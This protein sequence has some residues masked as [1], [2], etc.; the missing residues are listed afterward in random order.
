MAPLYSTLVA[1]LAG[2]SLASAYTP[3]RPGSQ[4]RYPFAKPYDQ[5]FLDGYSVFKHV[6]GQGPYSNRQS[7]GIS[8]DPP[9]GCAVDQVIM[10][11]RHGER[12]PDPGP[13]A[14]FKASLNK[15]YATNTTAFTGALEFLN[16]WQYFI[17]GNRYIA[18][19]RTTGP[20]P[21]CWTATA[22][23]PSTACGT[24]TCGTPRPSM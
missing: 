3:N 10:L 19:S 1:A 4:N 22:T 23:A 7:Y 13:A 16:R 14:N 20:T 12:W 5:S 6:G 17:P 15:I 24:A 18:S 21:A 9:D 8:R 2:A 11:K